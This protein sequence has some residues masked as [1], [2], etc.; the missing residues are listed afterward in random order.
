MCPSCLSDLALVRA[1]P[2]SHAIE[3]GIFPEGSHF[4]LGGGR[5]CRDEIKSYYAGGRKTD[6]D[7]LSPD[8]LKGLLP[9]VVVSLPGNMEA[10]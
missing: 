7:D 9:G 10:L 3:F 2:V 4:F 8:T 6:P 5:E 1:L